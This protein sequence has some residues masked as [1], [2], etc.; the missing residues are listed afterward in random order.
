MEKHTDTTKISIKNIYITKYIPY[1][2]PEGYP[3]TAR[4][5]P[6]ASQQ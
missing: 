1:I 3:P 6:S 2:L 5:K 4:I